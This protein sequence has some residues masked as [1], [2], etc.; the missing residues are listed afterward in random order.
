MKSFFD[1]DEGNGAGPGAIR[2]CP[3][4]PGAGGTGPAGGICPP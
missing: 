1:V 3:G 4:A 2:G